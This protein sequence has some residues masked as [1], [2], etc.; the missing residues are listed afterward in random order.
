MICEQHGIEHSQRFPCAEYERYRKLTAKAASVTEHETRPIEDPNVEG[1]LG[2]EQVEIG[3]HE[4]GWTGNSEVVQ[5]DD[6]DEMRR[7]RFTRP[8]Q[9]E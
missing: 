5:L 6:E 4:A 2:L 9:Y 3:K 1:L 7:W 8:G